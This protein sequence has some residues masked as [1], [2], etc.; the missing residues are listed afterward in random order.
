MNA[1]YVCKEKS[2]LFFKYIKVSLRTS[3]YRKSEESA[4]IK[5][6]GQRVKY[7][8]PHEKNKP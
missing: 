3:M 2:G 5:S 4:N 6:A 7:I 8:K 1:L